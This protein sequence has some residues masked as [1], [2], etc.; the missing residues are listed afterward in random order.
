[1]L[2]EQDATLTSTPQQFP[3]TIDKGLVCGLLKLIVIPRHGCSEP[4]GLNGMSLEVFDSVTGD[5]RRTIALPISIPVVPKA[6]SRRIT[7]R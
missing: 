3:I 2:G 5:L 6:P 7:L 1:V 4:A